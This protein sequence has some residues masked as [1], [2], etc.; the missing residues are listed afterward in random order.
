MNVG[1]TIRMERIFN[2]QTK[3]TVMVPMDHGITLGPVAGLVEVKEVMKN[4]IEGGANA[5]IMHKGIVKSCY[6][7]CQRSTGLIVHLSASTNLNPDPDDKI[8]VT[9]PDEAIALGGGRGLDTRE[10]RLRA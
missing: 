2:K 10:H 4:A 3:K 7:K 5:L 9:T 6:V 8:L 1:K